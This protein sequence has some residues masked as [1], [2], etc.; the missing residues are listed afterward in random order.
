MKWP[1]VSGVT[2]KMGDQT[3][4]H[5]RGCEL[6]RRQTAF[7]QRGSGWSCRSCRGLMHRAWS[8]G[9]LG[10]DSRRLGAQ[11][12]AGFPDVVWKVLAH[13]LACWDVD[14]GLLRALLLLRFHLGG[15]CA[16]ALGHTDRT[17]L[18]QTTAPPWSPS[19]E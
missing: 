3:L 2:R 5:H 14:L 8:K 11:G 12:R 16:T 15:G 4:S 7:Y 13:R 10:T 1:Q 9:R 17:D 18:T 6:T 19:G